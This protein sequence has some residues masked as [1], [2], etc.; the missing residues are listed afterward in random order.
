MPLTIRQMK[1]SIPLIALVGVFAAS[2]ASQALDS[3]DAH[4]ALVKQYC[5]GCH[6]DKAKIGG[7][8]FQ[9]ITAETVAKDP[10]R[11]E[12]GRSASCAAV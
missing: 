5:V 7:I 12:K 2:P 6:N 4:L 11:F 1:R 9:D 8:T 10:E 3:P